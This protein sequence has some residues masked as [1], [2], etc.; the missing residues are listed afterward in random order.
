MGKLRHS[1]IYSLFLFLFLSVSAGW[2]LLSCG[3]QPEQPGVGD[4]SVGGDNTPPVGGGGDN[5]TPSPSGRNSCSSGSAC[6]GDTVCEE[7]C[8]EMFSSSK[9]KKCKEKL[10]TDVVNE[11]YSIFEIL[12]EKEGFADINHEALDCLLG[13]SQTEF[14]RE[15]GKLRRKAEDF[16]VTIAGE[17]ELAKVLASEDDDFNILEKFLETIESSDNIL[18]AFKVDVEGSTTFIDLILEN[19]NEEAWEWVIEYIGEECDSGSYCDVTV[20]SFATNNQ[21]KELVFFCETFKGENPRKVEAL[22]EHEFFDDSYGGFIEGQEQCGPSNALVKCD[23]DNDLHFLNDENG[24]SS[25]CDYLA[26][27]TPSS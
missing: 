22:V 27:I 11:I 9:A 20:N 2:L 23:T 19:E 24:K 7:L 5:T 17:S 25:I 12:E 8:D 3:G 26:N 13:I 15:V 10:S 18:A 14:I 1:Y 21:A 4:F 6:L 16:L